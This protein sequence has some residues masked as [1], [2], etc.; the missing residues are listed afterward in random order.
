MQ[1]KKITYG[2]SLAGAP[3]LSK[4]KITYGAPSRWCAIAIKKTF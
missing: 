1:Q 3:L 4:K 2:A